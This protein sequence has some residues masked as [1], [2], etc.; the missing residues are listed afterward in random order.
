M[1][2]ADSVKLDVE[3]VKSG[4]GIDKHEKRLNLIVGLHAGQ[5]DLADAGDIAA[6][7]F[8]IQRDEAKTAVRHPVSVGECWPGLGADDLGC[9]DL[10]CNK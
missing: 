6:G 5:A 3:R 7:G 8:N 4:A 2:R 9:P 1:I 10:G